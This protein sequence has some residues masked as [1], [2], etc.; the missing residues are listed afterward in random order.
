MIKCVLTFRSGPST[1][2]ALISGLTVAAACLAKPQPAL[3]PA[4]LACKSQ[5][6]HASN[7]N[8]SAVPLKYAYEETV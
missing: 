3:E 1:A 2:A 7:T 8:C 5:L 6:V 4:L